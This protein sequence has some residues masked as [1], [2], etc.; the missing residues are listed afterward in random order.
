MRKRQTDFVPFQIN[1]GMQ[2][3][4]LGGASQL[5]LLLAVV[6]FAFGCAEPPLAQ[7]SDPLLPIE[8]RVGREFQIALQANP[9]TGYKWELVESLDES[10]VKLAR[11]E[12]RR[13]E[14]ARVGSG[15]VEV[16]TFRAVG[17]GTTSLSFK[18]VRPWEK[19]GPPADTRTFKVSIRE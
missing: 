3:D 8:A 13:N 2:K 11:S 19:T 5:S 1:G 10:K 9:T 6:F 18:Y 17:A 12:Y 16:W 4:K 7:F 14:P 15:G